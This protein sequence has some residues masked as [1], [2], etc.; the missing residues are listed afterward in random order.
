VFLDTLIS[1]DPVA[2][3]LVER[4]RV[5]GAYLIWRAQERTCARF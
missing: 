5:R 1:L 3:A 2:S 4:A